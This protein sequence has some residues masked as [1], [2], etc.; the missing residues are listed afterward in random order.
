M[1]SASAPDTFQNI[2]N[3]TIF[4]DAGL[5]YIELT[6]HGSDFEKRILPLQWSLDKVRLELSSKAKVLFL[7][8]IKCLRQS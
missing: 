2:V 5:S 1:V 7:S 6:N 4:A 8:N 3:Y